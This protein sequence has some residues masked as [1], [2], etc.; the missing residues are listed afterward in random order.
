VNEF[1]NNEDSFMKNS[2]FGSCEAVEGGAIY[3]GSSGIIIFDLNF[4]RNSTNNGSG[5]DIFFSSTSSQT[6]YTTTSLEL[7]CSFS[8]IPRFSLFDGSSLDELLPH[9]G[10]P[11][12]V[13]FV[14]SSGSY[15]DVNTCLNQNN[16]CRSL[17][18]VIMRGVEAG[19]EVVEIVIMG[20][21][22]DDES[23]VSVGKY[24]HIDSPSVESLS[25]FLLLFVVVLFYCVVSIWF[26]C[27][28]LTIIVFIYSGNVRFSSDVTDG[29]VLI[30]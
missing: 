24:I 14:G 1:Y 20:E 25:I 27:I 15:D 7:C 10:T 6:F 21:Y 28:R 23:V 8:E 4:T 19:N 2:L 5:N 12:G 16:P 3:L 26:F 29:T 22:D 11:L 13:R 17:D 9:C 18:V 30:R